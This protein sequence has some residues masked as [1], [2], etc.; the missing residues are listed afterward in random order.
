MKQA[1][2]DLWTIVILGNMKV[3]K[4]KLNTDYADTRF[5]TMINTFEHHSMK[6]KEMYFEKEY[7][8]TYA[9]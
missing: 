9:E 3:I 4:K 2:Y 8:L 7:W 5:D 1:I 6:S